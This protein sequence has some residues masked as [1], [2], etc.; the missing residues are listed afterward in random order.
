M[1]D[2]SDDY[3]DSSSV[4]SSFSYQSNPR[5]RLASM[6][7]ITSMS[8]T[9]QLKGDAVGMDSLLDQK[10][11]Q[12]ERLEGLLST[13]TDDH[14][15]Q[16]SRLRSESETREKKLGKK[17]ES[18]V[19]KGQERLLKKI[20]KLTRKENDASNRAMEAEK[21][22]VMVAKRLSA[23]QSELHMA[24]LRVSE[25]EQEI[26]TA[27]DLNLSTLEQQHKL[28]SLETNNNS[29][30]T[31]QRDQNS[32][33]ASEIRNLRQ[34]L[35][36]S[37]ETCDKERSRA[38]RLEKE[39]EA[40]S[41][42]LLNM[43]ENITASTE[44]NT[45]LSRSIEADRLVASDLKKA[46]LDMKGRLEEETKKCEQ[47]V[48]EKSLMISEKDAANTELREEVKR[49]K[50][51]MSLNIM[52]N[53]L[54]M[55]EIKK[56]TKILSAM[57]QR[58]DAKKKAEAELILEKIK[59]EY[60]DV[61]RKLSEAGETIESLEKGRDSLKEKIRELE[62][63]EEDMKKSEEEMKRSEE[64]LKE[65]LKEAQGKIVE[66]VEV[67]ESFT[68][69]SPRH[70]VVMETQ[71]SPSKGGGG[72]FWDG[73]EE[74][75]EEEEEEEE[76][77]D[78]YGE[79]ED[80]EQ[81]A[82]GEGGTVE[83]EKEEAAE[84]KEEAAEEKE[85]AAEDKEDKA[86]R[87]PNTSADF[88]RTVQHDPRT[89]P[90]PVTQSDIINSTVISLRST[91]QQQDEDMEAMKEEL[92]ALRTEKRIAIEQAG[93]AKLEALE[94]AAKFEVQ[95]TVEK[96]DKTID[97]SFEHSARETLQQLNSPG[98]SITGSAY[99][100]FRARDEFLGTQLTESARNND[101]AEDVSHQATEVA[102]RL[103]E[104]YRGVKGG[105]ASSTTVAV[106]IARGEKER[107][108]VGFS[109]GGALSPESQLLGGGQEN[110]LSS[111]TGS[112]VRFE[113]PKLDPPP[114][115]GNNNAEEMFGTPTGLSPGAKEIENMMQEMGPS[116]P[117]GGGIGGSATNTNNKYPQ[118]SELGNNNLPRL[119]HDL[120]KRVADEIYNVGEMLFDV[121]DSDFRENMRGGRVRNNAPVTDIERHQFKKVLQK[122]SRGTLR[123]L[124][125]IYLR[126]YDSLHD[127]LEQKRREGVK[128]RQ[129][130][131]F[132]YSPRS[133]RGEEEGEGEEEEE[134][135]GGKSPL[136]REEMDVMEEPGDILRSR[137]HGLLADVKG[138]WENERRDPSKAGP[139]SLLREE[140]EEAGMFFDGS[141]RG[142]TGGRKTK[143]TT[144]PFH[145]TQTRMANS[146]E[147][148]MR[149][150]AEERDSNRRNKL[151]FLD[152]GAGPR[153]FW[154]TVSPSISYHEEQG[155]EVSEGEVEQ[156]M[157]RLVLL[158]RCQDRGRG[159]RLQRHESQR[160]LL[161]LRLYEL[162]LMTMRIVF[163]KEKVVSVDTVRGGGRL[164]LKFMDV[165]KWSGRGDSVG[166]GAGVGL[167]GMSRSLGVGG[168]MG[169]MGGVEGLGVGGGIAR[170]G[171]E[172]GVDKRTFARISREFQKLKQ[173]REMGRLAESEGMGGK[174]DLLRKTMDGGV[175]GG[176]MVFSNGHSKQLRG[177]DKREKGKKGWRGGGAGMLGR[178]SD[179]RDFF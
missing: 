25:L 46:N 121:V 146:M 163:L 58:V 39:V 9:V 138:S 132:H 57:K 45:R 71:T 12:I 87:S 64:D 111:S 120:R 4:S 69:M 41:S 134:G 55:N 72:E 36:E 131:Q 18:K 22:S 158:V 173:D 154:S 137:M 170:E 95:Q 133:S 44:E 13:Q 127:M 169:L 33:L 84:E 96:M 157:W 129:P 164:K 104:V 100:Q 32:L 123:W 56:A 117:F 7:S 23:S 16:M 63:K 52:K 125:L 103:Y 166:R 75:E 24:K 70:A 165:G 37:K 80:F 30:L 108:S 102:G 40:R 176:A 29:Q 141:G 2:T 15:E 11:G 109:S 150:E 10:Q 94:L 179:R 53:M 147:S 139:G 66:P 92:D 79:D 49:M 172:G 105:E 113:T 145:R 48:A 31:S 51:N 77:V 168:L 43:Q 88:S 128:Q 153:E 78:S 135:W 60:L 35:I 14:L 162:I 160:K 136:Y 144:L 130:G 38:D 59:G 148:R 101:V 3:A 149:G 86:P 91:L 83:K 81:E 85:E 167:Q 116:A 155:G 73:K 171:I 42:R 34:Q 27:K 115:P 54:K 178:H 97:Q 175:G 151:N 174:G 28:T 159:L 19:K 119:M 21:R 8:N 126:T 152:S 143:S 114:P 20:E 62:V 93:V 90:I 122:A 98:G 118:Y 107:E 89:V 74:K 106:D 68:Q 124:L 61:T 99:A 140:Y 65:E 156:H 82:E 112:R 6:A 47:A 50:K 17:M 76:E 142:R 177:G 26:K 5:Q 161:D 1:S 67:N 110:I